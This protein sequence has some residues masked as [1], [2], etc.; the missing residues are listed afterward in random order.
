MSGI[1]I[2]HITIEKSLVI[3]G[4]YTLHVVSR[5]PDGRDYD[6][7]GNF[8]S[9][10]LMHFAAAVSEAIKFFGQVHGTITVDKEGTVRRVER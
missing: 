1:N 5:G 8:A 2:K 3:P 10:D 4:S 9:N 7:K 6:Y